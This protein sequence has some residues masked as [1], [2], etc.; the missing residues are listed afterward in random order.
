MHVQSEVKVVMVITS[1]CLGEFKRIKN[2]YD[3]ISLHH[4][5]QGSHFWD[6]LLVEAEDSSRE[7]SRTEGGLIFKNSLIQIWLLH[8]SLGVKLRRAAMSKNATSISTRKANATE[9]KSSKNLSLDTQPKNKVGLNM[10]I[11]PNWYQVFGE[12]LWL[13][14]LPL[15]VRCSVFETKA[16]YLPAV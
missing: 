7:E 12:Y 11:E 2:V 6:L 5:N 10:Q 14:V 4:W 15:G 9:W 3:L 8:A 13:K 16:H 1:F